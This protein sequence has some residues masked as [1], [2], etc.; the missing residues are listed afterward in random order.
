MC[1]KIHF[2]RVTSLILVF[3]LIILH[4]LFHHDLGTRIL[5]HESFFFFLCLATNTTS[6]N[7]CSRVLRHQKLHDTKEKK[8]MKYNVMNNNQVWTIVTNALKEGL[9]IKNATNNIRCFPQVYL[10]ICMIG[11]EVQTFLQNLLS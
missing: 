5:K 3:K 1:N 8:Q 6:N 10:S 7:W 4:S 2:G 9:H 11:V